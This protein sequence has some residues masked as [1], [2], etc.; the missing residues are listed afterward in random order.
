MNPAGV[1][2]GVARIME[3]FERVSPQD[4][5]HDI[6]SR[7]IDDFVTFMEGESFGDDLTV[8][9]IKRKK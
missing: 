1:Q 2:Y 5:A 3:S 9:L 6:L 8:I 4:S 7:I